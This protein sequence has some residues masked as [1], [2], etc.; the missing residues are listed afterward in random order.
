MKAVS[1]KKQIRFGAIHSPFLIS[2]SV[3]NSSGFGLKLSDGGCK[4]RLVQ[5]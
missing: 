2:V 3:V 4:Y 5:S 1:R